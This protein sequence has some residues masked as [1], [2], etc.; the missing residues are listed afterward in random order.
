MVAQEVTQRLT[1]CVRG[2]L[3]VR[4][5][6]GAFLRALHN[7]VSPELVYARLVLGAGIPF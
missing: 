6:C 3:E 1:A 4:V 7:A 2:L 5:G